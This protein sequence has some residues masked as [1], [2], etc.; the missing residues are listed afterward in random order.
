M[1]KQT[2]NYCKESGHRI[3]AINAQG[4]YILGEDGERVLA[5]PLLIQKEEQKTK[6][7]KKAALEE[8]AKEMETK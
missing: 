5:C 8:H 3:H 4:V 7:S 1:S 2:C 6:R